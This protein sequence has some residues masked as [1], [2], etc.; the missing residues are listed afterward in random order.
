MKQFTLKAGLAA[1]LLFAAGSASA[2]ITQVTQTGTIYSTAAISEYSTLGTTM[3]GMTVTATWTIDG[4]TAITQ[5]KIW[6][7]LS[8]TAGGV[9]FSGSN[10]DL[11]L[12]GDSF[13]NAWQLDF[14]VSGAGLLQS[15]VFDGVPGNTVFDICG[16]SWCNSTTGPGSGTEGSSLGHNFSWNYGTANG[17]ATYSNKVALDGFAPVGDLFAMFAL[18]FS[19]G[20]LG[21][22]HLWNFTLDTDNATTDLVQVPE[23][24]TVAIIGLGLLG[25]FAS[26]RRNK[27]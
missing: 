21:E 24:G 3:D 10:F 7:D 8:G 4:G 15:L 26:R 1:A 12:T 6:A 25:L 22:G 27:A 19:G 13:Y 5:T 20:G 17:T 23:P 14:E 11:M 2:A 16:T 9:A 18:D